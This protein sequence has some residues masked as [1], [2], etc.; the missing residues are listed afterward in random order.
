MCTRIQYSDFFRAGS[1]QNNPNK[2]QTIQVKADAQA[3]ISHIQDFCIQYN[4]T[5]SKISEI[6]KELS[7]TLTPYRLNDIAYKLI[8][9]QSEGNNYSETL[10]D[11]GMNISNSR[12]VLDT[13]ILGEKIDANLIKTQNFFKTF[14]T[15]MNEKFQ[16]SGSIVQNNDSTVA[17]SINQLNEDLAEAEEQ[18]TT[19]KQRVKRGTSE[20][21]LNAIMVQM[22]F[23]RMSSFMQ[24]LGQK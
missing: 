8:S 15:Q 17:R 13:S 2:K 12:L 10:G 23:L 21:Q 1:L 19:E 11:Y 3:I 24:M 6:K 14:A 4:E 7:T 22:M 20:S 5:I 16:D 9:Y 18:L